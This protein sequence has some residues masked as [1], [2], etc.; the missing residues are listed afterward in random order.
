MGITYLKPTGKSIGWSLAAEANILEAEEVLFVFRGHNRMQISI[1]A[2]IEDIK[3]A[4]K[5]TMTE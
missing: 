2:E 5:I 4:I 1:H 3:E